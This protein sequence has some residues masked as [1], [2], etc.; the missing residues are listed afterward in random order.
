[1][2]E[3]SETAKRDI[4]WKPFFAALI[5]AP[6]L[7]AGVT[8]PF[9]AIPQIGFVA[10]IPYM[11]LI[12]GG[13]VYLVFGTPILIWFLRRNPPKLLPIVLLSV[14]SLAGL[15]PIAVIAWAVTGDSSALA[16]LL[17]FLTYGAVF[18]AIWSATFTILYRWLIRK[19]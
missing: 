2:T 15:V 1:M 13:P 16:V 19:L 7:F 17:G 9:T 5:I 4:P 18:A 3:K 11:A 14:I 6:L 8:Y 12:F 10:A